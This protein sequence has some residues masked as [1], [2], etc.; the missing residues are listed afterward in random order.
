MTANLTVFMA[1][2]AHVSTQAE[3]RLTLERSGGHRHPAA[4]RIVAALEVSLGEVFEYA[5]E[6]TGSRR[7]T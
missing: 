2:G 4:F 7:A 5:A 3:P 6:G 1:V